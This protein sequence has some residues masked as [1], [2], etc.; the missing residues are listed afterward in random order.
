M[1]KIA[2]LLLLI[3]TV[4]LV[5][6]SRKYMNSKKV[7]E[8]SAKNILG[9]SNYQAICYGGY[10]FKSRDVEPTVAEITDDLRILSAMNIKI[11]RTY[12]VHHEE[13]SN[14]L[15]AIRAL[16]KEDPN[17]EM[18]VMLGAWIDCKNAWTIRA[19][20][21]KEENERNAI[22]IE[23]AVKLANEYP[24]IVKVIAV[25]NEA[26]VKWA[27]SYYVEPGIILKWVNHLQRLKKEGKLS[28]DLWVTSSDNFASWGGG[29]DEY[30]VEELRELIK[31]VD[32]ISLHTYPMHDT[33]YNP[34]FWGVLKNEEH[35]SE[36]EKIDAAMVRARDYAIYQYKSVSNYLK[37]I[38]VEKPIHIGETGWATLSNE[39]YG[40]SGSKATDEYKSAQYYKLMREWTNREGIAL[41]YFEAFDEQWKDSANSLGSEN[42]F[43]LINLQ[44]QAKYALWE[45]VDEGVF[46]GLTRDGKPI[47]KTYNGNLEALLLDAKT[48]SLLIKNK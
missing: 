43:G 32:Y 31:A 16:K 4:T 41:F 7:V 14:L 13:A 5:S 30:H 20:I 25:G 39:M 37:S 44:A 35:L 10:R 18:Y 27:T 33:H 9:N 3:T 48:P 42:H 34:E 26:M 36:R 38:G 45:M 47:T 29:S 6:C 21:H 12:N 23:E 19:P 8:I 46:K 28:K 2:I 1:N 17:F 40:N 22:E 24:E 15:K 11:L